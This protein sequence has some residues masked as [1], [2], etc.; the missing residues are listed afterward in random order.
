MNA[1]AALPRGKATRS[2][3]KWAWR[4]ALFL[5]AVAA[6]L[7]TFFAGMHIHQV[8]VFPYQLLATAHKT[9]I[10]NAGLWEAGGRT[11]VPAQCAPSPSDS[12]PAKAHR[13]VD[14]LSKD[15]GLRQVLCPAREDGAAARVEF[16]VGTGLTDPILN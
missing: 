5:I 14:R 1:T 3:G 13:H 11:S 2:L 7:G 4:L 12:Q 9:L 10:V 8:R 16:V 15:L 6:A